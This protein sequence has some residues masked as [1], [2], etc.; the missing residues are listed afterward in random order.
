[1]F[2][3][4]QPKINLNFCLIKKDLNKKSL[5]NFDW[6]AKNDNTEIVPLQQN[7]SDCTVK[8]ILKYSY[9]EHPVCVFFFL[10]VCKSQDKQWSDNP[11]NLDTNDNFVWKCGY[12]L[13]DD[14]CHKISFR[15]TSAWYTAFAKVI[16]RYF[17]VIIF[18]HGCHRLHYNC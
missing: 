11:N 12:T 2:R 16:V 6:K 9:N 17:G 1:M 18:A 5:P 8:A 13:F 14:L 3:Q 7:D 15:N 4:I 10:R